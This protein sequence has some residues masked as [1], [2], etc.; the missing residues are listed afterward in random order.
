MQSRSVTSIIPDHSL[1]HSHS[2]RLFFTR[3]KCNTESRQGRF[4]INLFKR[5]L[6]PKHTCQPSDSASPCKPESPR[7]KVCIKPTLKA[8]AEQMNTPYI[9]ARPHQVGI[10]ENPPPPR[11]DAALLAVDRFGAL[12]VEVAPP[13]PALDPVRDAPSEVVRL[14]LDVLPLAFHFCFRGFAAG[15]LAACA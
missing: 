2:P 8:V 13:L 5:Y 11:F 6:E 10:M 3:N 15:F 4:H 9:L 12:L 1:K 7:V 14:A